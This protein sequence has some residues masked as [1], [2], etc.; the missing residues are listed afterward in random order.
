MSVEA[1]E[2][3]VAS[4]R[5]AVLESLT[6]ADDGPVLDVM[7]RAL[8]E[9]AVR[10]CGTTLDLQGTQLYLDR[11]LAVGVTPEQVQEMLVLVS[12]IGIH[13]MLACSRLV[14]EAM[15]QLPDERYVA[16]LTPDQRA[17][18]AELIGDG[19]REANTSQVAPGFLENILRLCS[20][21]VARA[22]YA[23]RAAPWRGTALTPLQKELIGIAVD[24]M[25]SHRFLPTLRLHVAN[26][27]ALGAGRLTISEVLDISG[28][29][30]PHRGVW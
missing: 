24:T 8:L 21:D 20:P 10:A 22:I 19:A 23:F 16:P 13:A 2:L 25:P 17:L 15:A 29:A 3:S 6:D 11:A 9:L 4:A 14:A 12:G 5:R 26:A 1:R 7:T 18:Q 28:A 30:P 27:V